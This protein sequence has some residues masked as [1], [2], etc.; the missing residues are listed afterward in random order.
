[1]ADKNGFQVAFRQLALAGADP[2]AALDPTLLRLGTIL[3]D[4]TAQTFYEV[5]ADAT[6]GVH[7]WRAI[8]GAGASWGKYVVSSQ[9]TP[10]APYTGVQQGIEAAFADLHGPSNPAVV[11]VMPG[12]YIGAITLRAGIH[13]VA[14]AGAAYDATGGV[15]PVSVTGDVT[16]AYDGTVLL[17][18]ISFTGGFAVTATTA[19]G[20]FLT[21]CAVITPAGPVF[22]VAGPDAVTL[23]ILRGTYTAADNSPIVTS[24]T[25]ATITARDAT[26]GT[27][28]SDT[29]TA[30]ALTDDAA[31]LVDCEIH[32]AVT[33][34]NEGDLSITRGEW[35]AT[36]AALGTLTLGAGATIYVDGTRLSNDNPQTFTGAAGGL[37]QLVRPVAVGQAIIV[38][39]VLTTSWLTTD[40]N[41][42]LSLIGALFGGGAATNFAMA[43]GD[44]EVLIDAGDIGTITGTLPPLT[45]VEDGYKITVTRA[46]GGAAL[47][48]ARDAVPG[49]L[50]NNATATI[51]ISAAVGSSRTFMAV[52]NGG[53]WWTV[54]S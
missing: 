35:T 8:G 27:K 54:D 36:G 46:K 31:T 25:D 42:G 5:C 47:V 50:L 7:V 2:A 40:N 49:D 48:V 44:R 11:F 53:S 13:V 18:G 30:L 9:A 33:I 23:G 29:T 3:F 28:S 10:L 51:A 43:W 41:P 39:P 20:L 17:S 45:D 34:A 24:T 14:W 32:G 19:M 6:T 38:D 22:T 4:Q 12:A 16:A 37:V 21:D 1:M 26:L 15:T 52:K